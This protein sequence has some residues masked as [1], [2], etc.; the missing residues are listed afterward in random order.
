MGYARARVDGQFLR[1]VVATSGRRED[2]AHPIWRKGHEGLSR[3]T[4]HLVD[5]PAGE[6]G[7]HD[8][9]T[10]V[11]FRLEEDSPAARPASITE[12]KWRKQCGA[13]RRRTT[14]VRHRR[15]RA[16][17]QFASN[18]LADDVIRERQ[19]VFVGR[20]SSGRQRHAQMVAQ[21]LAS[22][23]FR[24]PSAG[25]ADAVGY[26]SM[27]YRS[28][29]LRALSLPCSHAPRTGAW[30]ETPRRVLVLLLTQCPLTG[31]FTPPVG[32]GFGG[33]TKLPEVGGGF[34]GRGGVG[35]GATKLPEVGGIVAVPPVPPASPVGAGTNTPVSSARVGAPALL[36]GGGAT[37]LPE[38]TTDSRPQAAT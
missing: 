22:H 14:R 21:D 10:Q 3:W 16:D 6:I 29:T 1:A 26:R 23:A 11:Q 20:L 5:A 4:R 8:V 15:A 13:E 17:H 7:N 2:F 25:D 31:G 30:L 38:V 12:L 32:G 9:L 36:G 24:L 33:G 37:K 18:N 34:G 27:S 35:G 28:R 19:Q